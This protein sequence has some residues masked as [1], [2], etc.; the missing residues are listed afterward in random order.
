MEA[1]LDN[2]ATTRCSD[3][4]CQL[5]VDLLTKDYGNPSSLHMK[6][7]EAERF[8]ETAKKKIAKTLRVLEKEIIFTSGGTESN[9]LAI[10]GAAMANRRAG[11]HII[12]TSIEHA[13][14][15]N[16]MEFLKEQGFDITYLS[17]DENGIISLE[18]LE[19]AVTEQTILV[20]MMQVNNEIGAIE[21]VAEAAEL[22]KKKN[23][24]TLIHVDAIQSYGKMYIY[25]KKLGIDML[26]VSGHKIH[27]PKGSGFLW[28][29]EKTKL[30]PLILGGG[31]Q[32]GM[33]SGTENVPAIAG[34]GEAAEE[35][36]ENLDEKRAH[37]YGLKQRFIDGIEKL[38]GT[39]VNGKTGE[40]SAPHIVSVSFEGIR[41]EVLL[42]S[43]EDR[44][45]YVSSGSACS[46]NNH[47]GKQ[48]GSKTLRNIHLKENLLD[49]TL[50][51]SFSV[52][53]TEEEIDYALE[54]L[55][56]LLPVLKKY[57]RH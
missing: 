18:E 28:V 20:S 5:M 8:V 53:T 35:I 7:I 3:R 2:S 33:R 55:G 43:L 11:N 40:D 47:A 44:G 24:D 49:S 46:S 38:E 14:V 10:I 52:H 6:G 39:H 54:V 36:Y 17:V 22:I 25:P 32:K 31:Q 51:F 48:K 34:L 15:E 45:I 4:A 37:L 1:Y 16:P 21:P 9:N 30:K 57:T 29:K 19:E 23:P 12:T 56:E 41:S 42:H 13:S 27:G 26:S 50:R